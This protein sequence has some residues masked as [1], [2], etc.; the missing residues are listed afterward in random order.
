MIKS[1]AALSPLHP[2]RP[3]IGRF[4]PS[5]TGPLHF[6][7]LVSALASYLHAQ[8]HNGT[9]LVRMEDLDPPREQAGAADAILRCLEAHQLQWDGAVLYQSQRL[10]AYEA[11]LDALR[12]EE[13]VYACDCTRQDLHAMGGIYNGRCRQR[14]IDLNQPHAWRLKLYDLPPAYAALASE[15]RFTDLLQGEQQQ[16]LRCAAG[17]QILKRK[18]DLFAYQLAVVVDDIAQQVTHIIRGNDLLEVTARQIFFFRLLG[19][20]VPAFGHVPLVLNA[21]GQ[22]LSKQNLAPP[23][24]DANAGNNLWHA[25]QFLGQNPP[26]VLQNASVFEVLEW[27]KVHWDSR[28]LQPDNRS[29]DN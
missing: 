12:R 27:G 5:P 10:S 20:A 16:N 4:A 9:W 6:G 2:P 3:Y 26:L 24:D 21:Q 17:D 19:A 28:N 22:K 29:A 1:L 13:L 15:V 23:L 7:S 11:V 18:D 14:I 25:L 8:H